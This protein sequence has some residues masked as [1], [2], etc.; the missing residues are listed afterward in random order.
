MN[1]LLKRTLQHN[2]EIQLSGSDI[3]DLFW[4]LDAHAQSDFFNRL[5]GKDRLVFQLQSVTDSESLTIG[6]RRVMSQIGEYSEA[7]VARQVSLAGGEK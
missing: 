6:G 4:E 3:A 7:N 5:C 2:V 1:A